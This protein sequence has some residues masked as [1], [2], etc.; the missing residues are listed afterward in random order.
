MSNTDTTKILRRPINSKDSQ[1]DLPDVDA[2]FSEIELRLMAVERRA[3]DMEKRME[4]LR[5]CDHIRPDT[6]NVLNV[7]TDLR[8]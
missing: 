1:D 8:H 5:N 3:E 7:N 6:F 2:R 4:W